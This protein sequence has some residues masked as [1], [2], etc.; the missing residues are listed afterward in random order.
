MLARRR[1][2]F[3]AGPMQQLS[4][5]LP[6]TVQG[7]II[8]LI[9]L[10]VTAVNWNNTVP[11]KM[12]T[13]RVTAEYVRTLDFQYDGNVL[14]IDSTK[15]VFIFYKDHYTP[16]VGQ[17]FP[18]G[19]KIDIY[20]E[21]TTPETV[22]AMQLYDYFGQPLTRYTSPEYVQNPNSYQT[23]F[24]SPIVGIIIILFG[25]VWIGLGVSK[26][27]L[28]PRLPFRKREKDLSK[29]PPIPGLPSLTHLVDRPLASSMSDSSRYSRI[30]ASMSEAIIEPPTPYISPKKS[31]PSQDDAQSSIPSE[32]S[33]KEFT[34]DP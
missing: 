4:S 30:S 18:K 27:N 31:Y 1:G 22:V 16:A 12:V 28:S 11:Y 7:I 25:L 24:I 2:R 32:Y 17:P 3:F 26:V 6:V 15:D 10:A 20:Y 5:K 21:A 13:G 34:K 14:T 29:I 33:F 8:V 9:G 23:G 19:D